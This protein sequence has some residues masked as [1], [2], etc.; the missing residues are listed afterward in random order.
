MQ[1]LLVVM[2]VL[3]ASAG[4]VFAE[5]TL[6]VLFVGNSQMSACDLPRMVRL[7]ADSA[8]ADRPRL[9][10]GQ[11]L[12]MGGTLQSYWDAGE[13]PGTARALIATGRWDYVVI[14]DLYHPDKG[15]P[16][17]KGTYIYACLLYACITGLNPEGLAAEFKDIAGGIAIAKEEAVKM[18]KAAWE[19]YLENSPK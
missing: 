7:M 5:G 9:E 2:L 14:L 16:G 15:H 6:K 1:M 17:F 11:A 8:P 3:A 13:K 4:Q 10:T 18:Q 12:L 19:Q